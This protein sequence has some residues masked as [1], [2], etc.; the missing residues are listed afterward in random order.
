MGKSLTPA[1]SMGRTPKDRN[2]RVGRR[3]TLWV[4]VLL[5]IC[6]FASS[7]LPAVAKKKPPI[8]RT[9]AGTVLDGSENPIVGASVELTDTVTGKMTAIYSQEEGKYMFSGLIATHDYKLQAR[10]KDV[11][12]EVRTVSSF[13]DRDH[14]VINL[15][16]PPPKE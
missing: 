9:V 6:A 7:S 16:I 12:S 8:A 10:Q 4:P 2:K 15:R 11:G 5:V 14:I 1:H 3:L 13:D